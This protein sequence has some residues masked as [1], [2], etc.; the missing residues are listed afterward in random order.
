MLGKLYRSWIN[1]TFMSQKLLSQQLFDRAESLR[2]SGES[3]R[4]DVN[5]ARSLQRI[6]KDMNSISPK[7]DPSPV[8]LVSH[9]PC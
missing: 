4:S 7:E 5:S 9:S 3:S 1:C 8:D 6:K 2:L